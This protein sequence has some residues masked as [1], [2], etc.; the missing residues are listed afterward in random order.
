MSGDSSK[1]DS[2]YYDSKKKWEIIVGVIGE[3]VIARQCIRHNN[4]KNLHFLTQKVSIYNY[5]MMR[6][7]HI[8]IK[9]CMIQG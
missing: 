5:K 9:P 2:M 3:D 4:I 1:S 6:M 8:Y 7:S